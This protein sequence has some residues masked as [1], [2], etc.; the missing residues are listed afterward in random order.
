MFVKWKIAMSEAFRL[1]Y[2]CKWDQKKWNSY[3]VQKDKA[4]TKS[5]PSL[6]RNTIQKKR[7]FYYSKMF[8][9][10]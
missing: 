8:G 4:M 9:D 7:L 5:K 1:F 6:K 3:Q 2:N 10:D